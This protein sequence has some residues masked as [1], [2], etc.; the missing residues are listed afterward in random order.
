MKGLVTRRL[1]MIRRMI[2]AWQNVASPKIM[3]R[4]HKDNISPVVVS[5]MQEVHLGAP[6]SSSSSSSSSSNREHS[7]SQLTNSSAHS[8]VPFS[9]DE[10]QWSSRRRASVRRSA[11]FVATRPAQTSDRRHRFS[12]QTA[13]QRAEALYGKPETRA[14]IQCQG[15]RYATT[16]GKQRRLR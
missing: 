13:I 3:S 1:L 4:T 15:S 6:L 14:R 2:A 12:H 16:R 11:S 5:S 9:H 10:N 8:C 7:F